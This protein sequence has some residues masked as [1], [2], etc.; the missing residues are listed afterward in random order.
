[1]S[2]LHIVNAYFAKQLN[3]KIHITA[4]EK[5]ITKYF[6]DEISSKTLQRKHY[7]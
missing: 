5:M 4:W 7:R 2:A 3:I 1:M 6:Q